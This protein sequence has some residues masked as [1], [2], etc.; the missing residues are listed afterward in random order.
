MFFGLMETFVEVK[1]FLDSVSGKKTADGFVFMLCALISVLVMTVFIVER[2][3]FLR[4]S[5]LARNIRRE[6]RQVRIPTVYFPP[7]L[8][9]PK[10]EKEEILIPKTVYDAE[11]A[12]SL[13]SDKMAKNLIHKTNFIKVF[14]K[15]KRIVNLGELSRAFSDGERADING[16]KAR[17]L[18]PYDTFEVKVLASGTLD[19]KLFVFANGFSKTAVKM[20]ALTGGEAV[21]LR[22][23]RVK[24][25]K[26]MDG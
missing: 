22:S 1:T 20:I 11:R 16:M 14:G 25:P 19:K 13:L 17:G 8:P 15:K 5:A 4:L 26:E 18:I 9:A 24:M 6:R 3:R 7:S 21:K 2:D 23:V 10:E 12:D